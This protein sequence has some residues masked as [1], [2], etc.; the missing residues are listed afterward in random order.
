MTIRQ[1]GDELP[2]P[3]NHYKE[4]KEF[5]DG[6]IFKNSDFMTNNLLFVDSFVVTDNDINRFLKIFNLDLGIMTSKAKKVTDIYRA[7]ITQT[8]PIYMIIVCYMYRVENSTL[9]SNT[10]RE[11]INELIEIIYIIMATSTYNNYRSYISTFEEA[12]RVFE[13]LRNHYDIKKYGSNFRVFEAKRESIYSINIKRIHK[14]KFNGITYGEIIPDIS[15][16]VRSYFKGWLQASEK[17]KED[18]GELKIATQSLSKITEE[19]H[20]VTRDVNDINA[21][22]FKTAKELVHGN[23]HDES[24]I[25]LTCEIMVKVPEKLLAEYINRFEQYSEQALRNNKEELNTVVEAIIGSSIN[26]IYIT[27]LYPPYNKDIVAI[28]KLTSRLWK[29]SRNTNESI[30]YVKTVLNKHIGKHINSR[31][32]PRVTIAFLCYFYIKTVIDSK[33]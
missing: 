20:N 32:S 25:K 21:R 33:T 15:G 26:Y 24:L 7:S 5:K 9:S 29:S 17:V 6:L 22:Q 3:D 8:K 2:S 16:K 1:F 23:L 11:Y 10:R 31:L 18:G 19:G 12:T 27:N 13:S 30:T 28:I 4:V 14:R